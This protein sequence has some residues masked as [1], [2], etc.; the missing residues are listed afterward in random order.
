MQIRVLTLNVWALPLGIARHSHYRMERIGQELATLEADVVALQEVWTAEARNQ[1]REAAQAA[2]YSEIW[3]RRPAFGGSGL[4]VMSRLPVQDIRF[5]PFTL[6]GLPQRPQHADYYGGKGFVEITL[7]TPA[8][9]LV[10]INTHLHA[11]YAPSDVLDEYEGIRAAQAIELATAVRRIPGPV[12]ALGDFNSGEGEPAR[13]ILLGLSGLEDAA[14]TLNHRQATCMRENP[15]RSPGA[16]DARIDLILSRR[17][18]EM[19]LHPISI[20]RVL[21]RPISIPVEDGQGAFS[22]HAGVLADFELAPAKQTETLPAPPAPEALRL[23]REQLE[24]GLRISRKRRQ[25]EDR[26]A[27]GGFTASALLGVAA[28]QAR[29]SRRQWLFGFTA[30][31][32]GLGL[33]GASGLFFTSR[34]IG[35]EEEAGYAELLHGLD[36]FQPSR[37]QHDTLPIP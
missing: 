29:R 31:L 8:G 30:G 9:P 36:S 35:T 12:I 2:G 14:D 37:P 26:Y 6:E 17:G 21:D 16:E 28:G 32:T 22:D 5:T 4:M 1:L 3:H 33:L 25:R 34:S 15:Y 24:L 10:L 13:R 23:A 18:E 27:A 11:G 20:R 7:E 19:G